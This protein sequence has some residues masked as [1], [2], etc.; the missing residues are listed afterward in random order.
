MNIEYFNVFNSTHSH[1]TPINDTYTIKYKEGKFNGV[2]GKML[3]KLLSKVSNVKHYSESSKKIAVEKVKIDYTEIEKMIFEHMESVRCI[4]NKQC[5]MIVMGYSQ[6][7]K[8]GNE[9]NSPM[10]IS[11]PHGYKSS[12]FYDSQPLNFAGIEVVIVPW[13]D[14]IF[15][16]PK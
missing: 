6:M 5:R 12:S 16:I 2:L 3:F 14:G 1:Y 8:L 7:V 4:Y 9:I 10:T 13:I 11:F 15:V